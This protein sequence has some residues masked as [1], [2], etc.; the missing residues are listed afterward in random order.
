MRG[1]KNEEESR[2]ESEKRNI[3]I[4]IG[5]GDDASKMEKKN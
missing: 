5:I 3:K 1:Q 2:G 4:Y